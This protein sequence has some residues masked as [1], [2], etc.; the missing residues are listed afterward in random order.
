M[1]RFIIGVVVLGLLTFGS[2]A[3]AW[4]NVCPSNGF[5]Y[6]DSIGK[7]PYNSNVTGMLRGIRVG[8]KIVGV[9]WRPKGSFIG[10]AGIAPRNQFY[11]IIDG[12][13]YT[14]TTFLRE[15]VEIDGK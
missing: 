5:Y 1:K 8:E 12:G 6:C 3:S 15:C 14:G 7:V 10:S 2:V 11:Y 4:Q 13:E 9:A